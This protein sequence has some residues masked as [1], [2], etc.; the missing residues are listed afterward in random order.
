MTLPLTDPASSLCFW[1]SQLLLF[2][3][4]HAYNDKANIAA[5]VL[6]Q[7]SRI[8]KIE[9]DIKGLDL[10][11]RLDHRQKLSKELVCKLF[12]N[13]KKYRKALPQKSSTAKAI[14]YA[15]NNEAALMRFLDDGKIGIDNNAAERAIRPI[16]ELR[17][18]V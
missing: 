11:K 5:S 7:I 1:Q 12:I 14:A 2:C 17:R 10:G 6:E 4:S 3:I 13:L 9:S 15:L 16:R 18:N 8:Y